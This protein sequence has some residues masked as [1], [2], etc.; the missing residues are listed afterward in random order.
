[1]HA[2]RELAKYEFYNVLR[3]EWR[4]GVA[5]RKGIGR[6]WKDAWHRQK[7]ETRDIVLG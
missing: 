1:M 3:V 6:V 7:V 5:Y 2:T 4:D